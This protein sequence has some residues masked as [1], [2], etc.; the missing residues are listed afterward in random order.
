[1]VASVRCPVEEVRDWTAKTGR[2]YAVVDGEDDAVIRDHYRKGSKAYFK[3][4]Y[5]E[6]R[7]YPA[8]V[9]PLPMGAIPEEIPS[10]GSPD[11]SGLLSRPRQLARPP[12][13]AGRSS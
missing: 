2:P 13:G 10:H 7:A 9:H 12:G 3:R 1:M 6:G 11:G 8:G 5:L 4:E